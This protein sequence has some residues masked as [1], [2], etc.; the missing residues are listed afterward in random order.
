[1]GPAMFGRLKVIA[2]TF[3]TIYWVYVVYMEFPEDSG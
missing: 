2:T 3:Y 1:M